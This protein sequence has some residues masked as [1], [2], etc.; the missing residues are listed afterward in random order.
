M[1]GL[2]RRHAKSV[3][4]ASAV[5]SREAVAARGPSVIRARRASVGICVGIFARVV[6]SRRIG[7]FKA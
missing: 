7:A 3:D 4:S 6:A 2:V 1:T 5:K